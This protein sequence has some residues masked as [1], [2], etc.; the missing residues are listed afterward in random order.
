[1]IRI[2]AKKSLGQNFLKNPRILDAIVAAAELAPG[3]TVL[4]VGPGTGTLTELLAK[5]ARNVLAIEKDHRLISGLKTA[6]AGTN[7]QIIEGDILKLDP[8]DLNLKPGRYSIVANIPYY[9]T[10]HL[11]RLILSVWPKPR[12]AVLMVQHEVAQRMMAAPPDMNLLGL[13]VQLYA[14]TRVARRVS[15]GNFSPPPKVDSAVVVL[16]P[17]TDPM[18]DTEREQVLSLARQGFRGKRK[19][20]A[21]TLAAATGKTKPE[22][23]SILEAAGLDPR[24]RPEKVSLPAWILISKKLS[25]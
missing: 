10:S 22:I 18:S 20:L 8:A 12:G 21:N 6:F 24:I 13:S 3:E 15:R 11:I 5:A 2:K 9:L 7:V 14:R 25:A 23:S 1:M 19:M 4:E 17:K 16:V